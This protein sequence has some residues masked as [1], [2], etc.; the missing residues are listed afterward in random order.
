MTTSLWNAGGTPTPGGPP[1]A[2][3]GVVAVDV[4]DRGLHRLGDVAA[5]DRRAGELGRGGEP[6]L[7]VDDEVDRAADPIAGDVAHRQGLGDDA[8]AGER[9]VAVDEDRQHG[10]RAGRVDL[11]LGGPDHALDDRVDGLQVARVGG[12]LEEDVGAG[13]AHVL[14]GRA[15]VVLHVARSLHGVGSTWPSNSRKIAS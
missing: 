2:R 10:I 13:R 4:E 14:A 3:L 8:L 12:E 7:V 11:V 9:G 1:H 5:V 6:D 15:E